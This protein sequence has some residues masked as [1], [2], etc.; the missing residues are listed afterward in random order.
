MTLSVLYLIIMWVWFI[1]AE[2]WIFTA[3]R[4]DEP[5][6]LWVVGMYVLVALVNGMTALAYQ[7]AGQ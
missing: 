3:M 4:R 5:R 7:H 1:G 6:L 2:L